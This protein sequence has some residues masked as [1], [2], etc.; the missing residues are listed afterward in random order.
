MADLIDEVTEDLRRQQ[1]EEFWKENK[2]WIIGGAIA[3]VILTG[4]MTFWRQWDYNR[5]VTQTASLVALISQPDAAKLENFAKSTDRNHAVVARFVAAG[6]HANRRETDKAA[7][8]YGE[9]AAMRG[10]DR[11]LKSLAAL[12]GIGQRL[13]KDD[14]AALK[15]ELA[16]LTD[17]D[18][19]WRFSALEMQALLHAR[20]G[21]MQAAVGALDK[22]VGDAQAPEDVRLRATTLRELYS[23]EVRK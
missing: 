21:N 3:A 6:L 12:L 19:I 9:I 8:I 15:K 16:P 14:P 11:D 2:Y 5:D 22:I 20:E 7:A 10:I 17:A 23:S 18:N 4:A 13:E 1:L